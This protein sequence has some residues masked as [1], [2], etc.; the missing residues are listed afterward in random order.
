[1]KEAKITETLKAEFPYRHSF[2]SLGNNITLE[3][4]YIHKSS[5]HTSDIMLHTRKQKIAGIIGISK[6][7]SP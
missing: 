2:N 1:M 5:I 4:F 3:G 7:C 6:I